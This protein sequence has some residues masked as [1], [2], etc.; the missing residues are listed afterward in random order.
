MQQ[1]SLHGDPH[2]YACLMPQ[3]LNPFVFLQS[4][5]VVLRN[6]CILAYDERTVCGPQWPA[7]QLHS[8]IMLVT[9]VTHVFVGWHH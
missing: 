1:H 9:Q 6:V 2:T 7:G 8:F 4:L 3:Q 5:K